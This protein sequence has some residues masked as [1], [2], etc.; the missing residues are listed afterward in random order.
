[1]SKK[2]PIFL[3]LI[4]LVVTSNAQALSWKKASDAWNDATSGVSDFFEQ[5][6]S[7]IKHLGEK[8]NDL[9]KEISEIRINTPKVDFKSVSDRLKI[10]KE[11]FNF[12]EIKKYDRLGSSL[13]DFR[14]GGEIGRI[15]EAIKYHWGPEIAKCFKDARWL[16]ACSYS[17]CKVDKSLTWADDSNK[18]HW[19]CELKKVEIDQEKLR[20]EID[21]RVGA[22]GSNI[23]QRKEQL[24]DKLKPF[25]D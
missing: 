25:A 22:I 23:D 19:Q 16:N 1:M 6:K 4:L 10:R 20:A 17:V 7:D 12:P 14:I 18:E 21:E 13:E 24:S 11:R 2:N 15:A 5:L 8:I 9:S 3:C